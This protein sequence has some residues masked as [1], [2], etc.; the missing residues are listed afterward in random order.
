MGWTSA[1]RTRPDRRCAAAARG[2][3]GQ[4]RGHTR[5]PG[6]VGVEA[7]CTDGVARLYALR[8]GLVVVVAVEFNPHP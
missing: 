3:P 5:V 2:D 8:S 1:A 6:L 7:A 4:H